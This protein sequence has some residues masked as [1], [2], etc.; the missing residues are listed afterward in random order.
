MNAVTASELWQGKTVEGKFPLLELLGSGPRGPIFR[1]EFSDANGRHSAAIKLIPVQPGD[2]AA[3]LAR[4]QPVLGLSHPHLMKIFAIGQCQI[5]REPAIYVVMEYAEENLAQVLPSRTLTAKEAGQ[6][7]PP[8]IKALS[9][10][11]QQRFVHGR[12]QPSNIMAV[13]DTLK[14]S[15]DCV[16]RTGEPTARF[17]SDTGGFLA[18]EATNG[19]LTLASDIWSLGATLVAALA[20]ESRGQPSEQQLTIVPTSIPEPFRRIARDCLRPNPSDRCTLQQIEG[21][22]GAAQ[23]VPPEQR[24]A[25]EPSGSSNYPIRRF[26]I[27]VV[28]LALALGMFWILRSSRF[29]PGEQAT[30]PQPAA[31][32]SQT[33]SEPTETRTIPGAVA[34]RVLP[35]VPQSARNTIQGRIRVAVRVSVDAAGNVADAK[36]TSPGPSKYFANQAL[37]SARRWK[38]EPPE[39]DGQPTAS[40]WLLKYQFG[41][42]GTEVAPTETH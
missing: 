27:P 16:R 7:L 4:L 23:A 18:P 20:V 31:N 3:H 32:S 34:E 38:F 19:T 22:L 36:L 10:L 6:M 1:T 41:R 15:S 13:G 9:Y 12:V 37:Q 39:V 17:P 5:R 14:L 30:S 29:K 35:N 40:T 26:G 25:I 24:D 21:W 42:S 33:N 2:V 11:H 8:L 28:V